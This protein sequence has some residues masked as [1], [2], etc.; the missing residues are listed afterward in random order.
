MDDDVFLGALQGS[1]QEESLGLQ[2]VFGGE[3]QTADGELA[4]ASSQQVFGVQQ[5]R[6]T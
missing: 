4:V 6:Q 2:R 3:L 1:E 5:A